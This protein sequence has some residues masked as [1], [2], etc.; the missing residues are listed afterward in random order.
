VG[1]NPDDGFVHGF[2]LGGTDHPVPFATGTEV[3]D[4]VPEPCAGGKGWMR[5]VGRKIQRGFTGRNF[6]GKPSGHLAADPVKGDPAVGIPAPAIGAAVFSPPAINPDPGELRGIELGK[7]ITRP[8]ERDR[9]LS[10]KIYDPSHRFGLPGKTF[11]DGWNERWRESKSSGM[12]FEKSG[13]DPAIMTV[14][15]ERAVSRSGIDEIIPTEFGFPPPVIISEAKS[16]G[17]RIPIIETPLI[18]RPRQNSELPG[19]NSRC[20]TMRA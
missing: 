8:V 4:M 11:R 16:G 12:D 9:V 1:Q 17:P 6:A 14:F 19:R 7:K 10:L 3:A 13:C 20:D 15:L 2:H 5:T 18:R